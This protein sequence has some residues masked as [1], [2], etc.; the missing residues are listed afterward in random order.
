MKHFTLEEAN[1]LIPDLQAMLHAAHEELADLHQQLHEANT[2]L[3][4]QE[5]RVRE[6]RID[7]VGNDAQLQPLWDEA[8]AHLEATKAHVE[9]RH[10]AWIRAITRKGVILRDLRK[11]LVDFPAF[12]DESEFHYCWEFG[13][14]EIAFWHG[15]GEGYVGRRPLPIESNR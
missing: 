11:G 8:A 10:D 14:A 4:N 2:E 6:A 15:D 1:S 13:E 9:E 3:L 5:W 12:D 7:G